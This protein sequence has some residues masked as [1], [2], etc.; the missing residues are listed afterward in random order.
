[1][2]AHTH[3][4]FI[5]MHTPNSKETWPCP[6]VT[7][8]GY[9]IWGCS[10]IGW[11]KILWANIYTMTRVPEELI[12]Q[13]NQDPVVLGWNWGRVKDTSNNFEAHAGLYWKN[14]GLYSYKCGSY[15]A[16]HGR[17]VETSQVH[18]ET[19]G[20]LCRPADIHGHHAEETDNAHGDHI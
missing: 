9:T 4:L 5:V 17:S 13:E 15:I 12:P 14:S 11:N 10:F 16:D 20:D 7:C 1:M 19:H 18:T 6:S 2:Y 8:T 3:T